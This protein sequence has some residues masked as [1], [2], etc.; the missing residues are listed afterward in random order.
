MAAAQHPQTSAGGCLSSAAGTW[1]WRSLS[2]T[3]ARSLHP[4]AFKAVLLISPQDQKVKTG[5][6]TTKRDCVVW[7][8]Y[9][10]D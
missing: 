4:E 7:S 9:T 6:D 10:G 3:L 1:D 8:R 5:G 2:P